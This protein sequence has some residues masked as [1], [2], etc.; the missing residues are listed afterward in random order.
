M[1][2]KLNNFSSSLNSRE[3]FTRMV[4]KINNTQNKKSLINFL[5]MKKI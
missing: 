1:K 4:K 5:K 2:I 3:K